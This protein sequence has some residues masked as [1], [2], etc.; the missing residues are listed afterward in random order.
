METKELKSRLLKGE[1]VV[2][3]PSEPTEDFRTAE[4]S[5]KQYPKNNWANGFKIMFNGQLFSFMTFKAFEKKLN[6][7]RIN[8]N[9]NIIKISCQQ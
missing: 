4:C 3:E 7:L 5:F 2:F 1:E 6:A 8:W 9:L